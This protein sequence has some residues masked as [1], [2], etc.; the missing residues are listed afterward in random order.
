MRTIR[1]AALAAAAAL[2]GNPAAAFAV[3]GYRAGMT[4]AELQARLQADGTTLREIAVG[5][6]GRT[7]L[8]GVN[9]DAGLAPPTWGACK[10]VIWMYTKPIGFDFQRFAQLASDMASE[11]GRSRAHAA[12]QAFDTGA[13]RGYVH[14]VTLEWPDQD[15]LRIL[16]MEEVSGRQTVS[17]SWQAPHLCR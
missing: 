14:T 2:S 3:D 17:Q 9:R 13:A 6:S 1:A 5:E 7:L 10:G 12:V 11:L 16:T 15:G 4:V 8:L